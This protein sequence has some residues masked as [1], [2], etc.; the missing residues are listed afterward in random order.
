MADLSDQLPGGLADAKPAKP[1]K[2][3]AKAERLPADDPAVIEAQQQTADQALQESEDF[4]SLPPEKQTQLLD[5][6]SSCRDH[7]AAT[8]SASKKIAVSRWHIGAEAERLVA[9]AKAD[10]GTTYGKQ[11]IELLG[12]SIGLSAPVISKARKLHRTFE[13]AQLKKMNIE[14]NGLEQVMSLGSIAFEPVVKQVLDKSEAGEAITAA[15][16]KSL[17]SAEIDKA[18]AGGASAD[19]PKERGAAAGYGT[20]SATNTSH[21][22]VLERFAKLAENIE[23]QVANVLISLKEIPNA[24]DISDKADGYYQTRIPELQTLSAN[25]RETLQAVEKQFSGAV[26][27]DGSSDAQAA[28]KA[29]GVELERRSRK[30]K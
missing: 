7:L 6:I 29:D 21:K 26:V 2:T 28:D 27:D 25:L 20:N 19:K 30:A 4:R 12:Q 24:T 11:V 17:A 23:G 5:A 1:T 9:D 10:G 18:D 16:V 8:A 3:Q 22:Q 15:E 14:L 13:L